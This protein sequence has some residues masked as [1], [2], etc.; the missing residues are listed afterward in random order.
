MGGFWIS[1][2]EGRSPNRKKSP[3]Y[4][5]SLASRSRSPVDSPAIASAIAASGSSWRSLS[6]VVSFAFSASLV[7]DLVQAGKSVGVS[8]LLSPLATGDSL[9]CIQ[10]VAGSIPVGST[11]KTLCSKE[12]RKV[13]CK[14]SSNPFAYGVAQRREH[15]EDGE[16]E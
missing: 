2:R 1:F 8:A 6:G 3:A 15:P 9:V 14:A 7:Q 4:P 13:F 16:A 11:L 12:L 5:R 10:E